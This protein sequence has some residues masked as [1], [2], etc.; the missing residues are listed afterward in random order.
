MLAV[1]GAMGGTSAALRVSQEAADILVRA[2]LIA[3]QRQHVVRPLL[4]H[5]GGD[6]TLAVERV[7][8][9]R[10]SPSMTE[11]LAINGHHALKV[12]REAL[13]ERVEQAANATSS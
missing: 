6:R 2:A 8:R 10:C 3:H 11:C 13:H 9:W 5:L 1:D 12:P 4:D 7:G